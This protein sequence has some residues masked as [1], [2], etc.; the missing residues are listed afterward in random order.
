MHTH[1]Y[2]YTNHTKLVT[3]I[4]P[5]ITSAYILT[6][7]KTQQHTDRKTYIHT[8]TLA[9]LLPEILV[10]FLMFL[11]GASASIRCTHVPLFR[12]VTIE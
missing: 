8:H 6:A 9:G 2:S 3:S 7:H 10:G 1:I 11:M 5:Y 4:H 12:D